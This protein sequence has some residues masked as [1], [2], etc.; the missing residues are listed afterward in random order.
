MTAKSRSKSPVRGVPWGFLEVASTGYCAD[1]GKLLKLPA[2]S[3]VIAALR[4]NIDAY[5]SPAK[6]L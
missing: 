1:T 2:C 3:S 5:R 4:N 6:P